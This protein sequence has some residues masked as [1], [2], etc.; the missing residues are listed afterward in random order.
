MAKKCWAQ[1]E[2]QTI[3]WLLLYYWIPYYAVMVVSHPGLAWEAASNE[4]KEFASNENPWKVVSKTTI[5]KH[6]VNDIILN[7]RASPEPT[8]GET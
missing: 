6:F 4:K 2:R 7:Y 8:Y 5:L 3:A 1:A